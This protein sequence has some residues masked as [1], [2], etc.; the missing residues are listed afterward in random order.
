VSNAVASPTI[1]QGLVLLDYL[2]SGRTLG[3]AM[4]CSLQSQETLYHVAYTFYSQAK[5]PE[6]MRVFAFLLAAN[7]MDRRFFNGFAACLHMQR[8]HEDALKYYG[9]ASVLDLTDPEPAMHSAECHLA[10]GNIEQARTSLDYALC[11]ARADEK[12]HAIIAR[13]EAMLAFLNGARE[14]ISHG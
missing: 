13:L 5:Y 2:M 7:H 3:E 8:R 11:Q 14:E 9:A 4:G 1:A 6:A 10:L 12:H